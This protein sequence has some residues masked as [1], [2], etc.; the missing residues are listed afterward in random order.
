M[1]RVAIVL[2]LLLSSLRL[3]ANE[4]YLVKDIDQNLSSSSSYPD[5]FGTLGSLAV[6]STT[7]YYGSETALYRTDG[8]DAG[9]FF[10]APTGFGKVIWNNRVWFIETDGR[11]AL[12][13]PSASLWS[14]DGTVAGTSSAG[15]SLPVTSLLPGPHHLYFLSNG[16][17]WRTDGTP[18]NAEQVSDLSFVVATH[19]RLG[20][21]ADFPFSAIIGETLFFL[22]SANGG[23]LQIWRTDSNG[24]VPVT[25]PTLDY[26][27]E[28]VTVGQNFYFVAGGGLWRSDGTSAGTSRIQSAATIDVAPGS[29]FLTS[30]L[31]VYFVGDDGS[32]AKLW[33]TDGSQ[34]GTVVLSSSLPGATSTFEGTPIARLNNGTL[35][36][37]GP[38]LPP[39]GNSRLGMWAYDGT[40]T[41]FLADAPHGN[42]S[43][44]ATVAATYA[45]F[46]SGGE[47][48]RTDGTIG[49]TFNLGTMNGSDGYHNWPMTA[50]GSTVF[51]GAAD[52]HGYELWKT[53][54]QS[55][56]FVKDILATTYGSAPRSLTP[57]KNGV[58]FTASENY[59]LNNSSPTRDLWFSDGTEAG[60]RKVAAGIAAY[61]PGFES[62]VR[63]GDRVVFSNYSAEAGYEPWITDGTTAGTRLLRDLVP[64]MNGGY[65]QSSN[66]RSF[67]CV[68]DVIYFVSLEVTPPNYD[69]DYSLWRS[70]GTAEGTLKLASVLKIN[71]SYYNDV[72][73]LYSLNH[74]I[75]LSAGGAFGSKVW[76]SDGSPAGTLVV[77]SFPASVQGVRLFVA[78]PYLYLIQGDEGLSSATLW[79]S[80]GTDSG[81][82]SLITEEYLWP[83]AEYKGHLVFQYLHPHTGTTDG[84]CT[85]EGTAASIVCFDP[86]ISAS[87]G[88]TFAVR[89]LN[90]LLYYNFPNLKQS[91]GVT[92]TDTG[93]QYVDK[94]LANAGGRLYAAGTPDYSGYRWLME[95]DGTLAGSRTFP[96]LQPSEAVASGGRLFI[97]NDELYALDLP[98]TPL[99]F[100]PQRLDLS[101][102]QVTITGRGF[103]SPASITVGGTGA[104][105]TGV[106]AT[107]I[108]FTA[109]VHI[110]GS[111]EVELT[112]GDHRTMTLDTPLAYGCAAPT[113]IPGPAPAAV[114]PMTPVQLQGSGGTRCSWSPTTGLD[115]AT[116]CAPRST[117]NTTTTYTLAV[118]NADGCQSTNNPTMTVSVL[119]APGVTITSQPQ[120]VAVPAGTGVTLSVGAT[121]TSL[122]YQWYIGTSGDTTT[123]ISGATGASVNVTPSVTTTYWVRVNSCGPVDSTSATVTVQPI[124]GASFYLLSPCRL[125]DT[126]GGTPLPANGVM[127]FVMTGKCGVP[128][129]A[130]SVA[131]NVTAVSPSA[132]GLV[133]LYPGPANTL[134]PVV[135]TINYVAGR[136]RANNARI[137]VGL[138]G[139]IN[140]YN[141]AGTS[142]NFLIDVSGYFK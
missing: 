134:H 19:Q 62:R 38:S 108:T 136:T 123:P 5:H 100:T 15:I 44:L 37:F 72:S 135:S 128:A 41:T 137:T 2:I 141:A 39:I 102:G 126:R 49:G 85:T 101:G 20:N 68:D 24:T 81:T 117:V 22:G 90:G 75:Y 131:I 127:N 104:Q 45:V 55:T 51:F 10:L 88:W 47:L 60:T 7:D 98:V 50:V 18:G 77:K 52:N 82:V 14:S 57:F 1:R 103:T 132:T 25:T 83:F 107:S 23:P 96:P 114:C 42:R 95:T 27:A 139:S 3:A 138:D 35:I 66:P 80:D 58:L 76:V 106:T 43:T 61:D 87:G 110:A 118:F 21:V 53:D 73:R 54:G 11:E 94:F 112:L 124:A 9:T 92:N 115:D 56:T 78:G 64:S 111:Y 113:A 120:S 140:I 28:L 105:V 119:P 67:T 130:I 89:Q 26:S 30:G 40:N 46:G 97:A 32:G 116:S 17:L 59:A 86:N 34:A 71:S 79:R 36:F 8:S 93:V 91:D 125:L 48:W 84:L 16:K 69:Y 142:L 29:L 33:R 31:F 4:P 13:S 129:G 74:K 65:A 70:D 109:P 63:C 133:T 6:F 99:S 121:G 12:Y 122:S